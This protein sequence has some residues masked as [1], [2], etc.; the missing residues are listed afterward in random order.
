MQSFT[1]YIVKNSPFWK[2][3]ISNTVS[4]AWSCR[5][6]NT[7]SPSG[8]LEMMITGVI[9]ASNL[10]IMDSYIL[11]HWGHG[12]WISLILFVYWN[13]KNI[14]PSLQNI[15]SELDASDVSK[16]DHPQALWDQLFLFGVVYETTNGFYG[17]PTPSPPLRSPCWMLSC[18]RFHLY[19]SGTFKTP[20]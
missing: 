13:L 16:E 1:V 5:N 2:S 11:F 6:E 19:E 10:W 3:G 18:V 14:S 8:C 12:I 4:R 17:Y 9:P 20:R 15:D 7:K